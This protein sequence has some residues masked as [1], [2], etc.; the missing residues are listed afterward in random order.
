LRGRARARR[1]A[2]AVTA[3]PI[4]TEITVPPETRQVELWF[5]GSGA[6]GETVWDSRFGENYRFDVVGPRP[7][8]AD[9]LHVRRS[10]VVD[11]ASIAVAEPAR[12]APGLQVAANVVHAV[13][14]TSVWVDVYYFDG[15][16]TLIHGDTLPLRP[17]GPGE[18]ASDRFVLDGTLQHVPAE[19]ARIVQY[20]LYCE[21]DGHVVTD[22]ELHQAELSR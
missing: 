12:L 14:P 7:R 6:S 13:D 18:G 22:G 8:P 3:A 19:S 11:A 20:R 21:L 2:T 9:S 16:A 10:A 5:E 15:A 1:P 17:A 4:A